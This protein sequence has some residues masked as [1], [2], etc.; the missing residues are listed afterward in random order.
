MTV[1]GVAEPTP[2][3]VSTLSPSPSPSSAQT[4]HPLESLRPSGPLPR[5]GHMRA[6]STMARI[7]QRRYL[8]VGVDQTTDLFG[9]RNPL[10]GQLQG[11]DIDIAKQIAQAIFGH[12]NRIEFKAITSQQR[13]P[14]IQNGSV[15]IVADSMT[16][17]CARLQQVAFSTDYFNAGQRVLV[18]I[19]SPVRS[20]SQLGHQKVCAASGTTSIETI[21]AQPSHPI[22]VAAANWTDCLVMMQQGQVA[23]ISTDDSVLAGLQAQD[24]ETKL[25]GPKFTFEPHGIAVSRNSPDLVRF[26]NAVLEQMRT[27]GQWTAL[28]R[29][30]IGN[31][32]GPVPAPPPAEYRS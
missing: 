2:A 16:I 12:P 1:P 29:Q 22:P 18:P 20:I 10:N 31:R 7:Y 9:Y 5:P 19:D 30:W 6:G 25:V 21:A 14:V 8:I 27:D 4:C 3:G 26:V 17:N 32:L 23:A 13:I 24:P 28:Y 11:F 15:D